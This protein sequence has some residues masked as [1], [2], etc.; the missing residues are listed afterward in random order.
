MHALCVFD[1][2]GE[3]VVAACAAKPGFQGVAAQA[4]CCGC[5]VACHGE[6]DST[7]GSCAD[8][9][10]DKRAGGAAILARR[11]AARARDQ[12]LGQHFGR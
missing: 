2:G 11:H 7:R 9:A 3:R 10:D 1:A 6:G 12:R 4:V 5:G 8:S